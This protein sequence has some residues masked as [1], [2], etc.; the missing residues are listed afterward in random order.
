MSTETQGDWWEEAPDVDGPYVLEDG[1]L[2]SV[3]DRRSKRLGG[4]IYAESVRPE[5]RGARW[6]VRVVFANVRGERC[7]LNLPRKAL[8]GDGRAL[9]EALLDAEADLEPADEN[10]AEILEYLRECATYVVEAPFR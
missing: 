9:R 2:W 6:K 4:L 8:T 5:R 1:S 10:F 3:R 7:E